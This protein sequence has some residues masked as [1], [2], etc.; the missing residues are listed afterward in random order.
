MKVIKSN[1]TSVRNIIKQYRNH[2][3]SFSIFSNRLF[4]LIY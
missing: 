2:A 1:F 4:L 3:S